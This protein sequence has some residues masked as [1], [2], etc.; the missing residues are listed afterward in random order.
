MTSIEKSVVAKL[1]KEGKKFEILVD[2]ENAI[3]LKQGKNIDMD[4]VVV[5]TDIFA[6][7][8]KGEHAAN[9][10]SFFSTENKLEIAKHIILEGEVQ[11]TT[12]YKNKLREEKR[13]QII[14]IIHRNGIDPKTNLPHPPLRIENAMEEAKVKIDEFK[15]GEEQAEKVLEKIRAIIPIKFLVKE[16]ALNIPV[17]YTRIIYTPVKK[18]AKILKE[19]WQNNGNLVLVVE[20]PGGIEQEMYDELNKIMKGE[21]E[22]KVLNTR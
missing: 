9:L 16:I 11:L 14:S 21:L 20:I 1:E 13:K 8:K 18:L 2:L 4:K 10:K 15:S 7:V 19:E 6:D 12:E 5:T 17:K 22:A 3:K